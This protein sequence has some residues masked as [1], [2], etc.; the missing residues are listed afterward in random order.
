MLFFSFLVWIS[1]TYRE[2]KIILQEKENEE[3]NKN[4]EYNEKDEDIKN[5][6]KKDDYDYNKKKNKFSHIGTINNLPI[7]KLLFSILRNFRNINSVNDL[8]KS[9]PDESLR[10]DSDSKMVEQ[11]NKAEPD[12]KEHINKVFKFIT[13]QGINGFLDIDLIKN[14]LENVRIQLFFNKTNNKDI[15]KIK[16]MKNIKKLIE[17]FSKVNLDKRVYPFYDYSD[18]SKKDLVIGIR[19]VPGTESISITICEDTSIENIPFLDN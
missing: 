13:P 9:L 2:Y 16:Y 5:K 14:K 11:M 3:D 8:K 10:E 4:M 6:A 17:E 18:K 19:K 1:L 15:N 7:E 12:I